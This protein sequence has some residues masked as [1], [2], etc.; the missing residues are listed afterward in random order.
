MDSHSYES[1][2]ECLLAVGA[3]DSFTAPAGNAFP[4]LKQWAAGRQ[5]WLLGHLAYD[6]TA[7]TEGVSGD[8]ADPI[9]FPDMFFFQPAHLILLQKDSILIGSVQEDPAALWQQICAA[10]PTP[11]QTTPVQTTPPQAFPP[12]SFT[13]RFTRGEYLSAVEALRRHILRGDC[14]EINFCQEFFTQPATI[15]PLATWWALGQAS[16]NPF[17]AF[18]RL[19]HRYLLC[20]SPERFLKKA[21]DTLFSQPIKGTAPRQRQDAQADSQGRLELYNSAKDRA[22]N[23]MVVDLV[24]NDLSRI[25]RP[26]SVQVSELFGIYPFP[27]V[28][29]M[30]STVTGTLLPGLDWTDTLRHCFP[31]G[32]MTGAPKHR[33]TQLIARYERSRR[34][35][36]SG[37]VGYVT[38]G[39]DLD[40]N[41]VIRSLLYNQQSRYLSYQ[42]GSGITWYSDPQAEYEECL[43]KAEGILKAL[44]Q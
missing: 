23:V 8:F 39:G 44:G 17:S 26:G 25:C 22:E 36:F 31:M 27:Q 13:P 33:V 34:G 24:R 6:L 5:D 42:V 16:P 10:Q 18:Y 37:A 14:Y 35:L 2:F 15:D 29:Q 1:S 20:A 28:Y 43:V 3:I 21:G 9:G 4:E 32:S 7:E 38:P 11:P 12:I 41:V 40:M 30:I 19:D